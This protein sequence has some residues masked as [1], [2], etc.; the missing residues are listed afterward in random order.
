MTNGS[1]SLSAP[2][3]VSATAI[4]RFL[5]RENDFRVIPILEH[6]TLADPKSSI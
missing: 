1:A 6:E 4:W 5:E 2:Y 3:V